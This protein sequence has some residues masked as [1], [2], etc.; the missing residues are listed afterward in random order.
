MK[1]KALSAY[2]KLQQIQELNLCKAERHCAAVYL[3]ALRKNDRTVIED[4]DIK[5]CV[6]IKI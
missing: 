1:Y 5:K 6:R 4:Y 2:E 3:N